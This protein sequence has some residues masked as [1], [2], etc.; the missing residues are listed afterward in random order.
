VNS[1]KL[2]VSLVVLLV[3]A[4]V[5]SSAV[6]AQ[7][8]TSSLTGIIWFDAN[9]NG[10]PDLQER[11]V[12][13]IQVDLEG[14]GYQESRKTT[15]TGGYEFTGLAA[16]TYTIT[17]HLPT[18]YTLSAG[19]NGELSVP[20]NAV[21]KADYGIVRAEQQPAP[22]LIPTPKLPDPTLTPVPRLGPSDPPAAAPAAPAA[23]GQRSSGGNPSFRPSNPA[24]TVP[25]TKEP[26]TPTPE[27]QPTRTPAPTVT[28]TPTRTPPPIDSQQVA[29]ERAR[30][31]LESAVTPHSGSS[32]VGSDVLL[33]V[34]FRSAIDGSDYADTNSGTAALA[35]ALESYGYT[36]STADLRAL[37]NV[38]SRTYDVGHPPRIDLLARAAEL[39]SV[40]SIGLYQGSRF[41]IWSADE[42]R[43]RVTAGYPVLT[44][45]HPDDAQGEGELG[46]E[47]YVLVIG[48]KDGNLIYHDPAYADKRGAARAIPL[49]S[50]T[51]VWAN[52]SG[53][54]QA[55]GLA[56]GKAELSLF[57]TLDELMKAQQDPEK[58]SSRELLPGLSHSPESQPTISAGTGQLLIVP[59]L[60]TSARTSRASAGADGP[61]TLHPI[62]LAFWVTAGVVALKVVDSLIRD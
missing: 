49:S 2:F 12:K 50:M 29:A 22:T 26:P 21:L 28:P 14:P 16:A 60:D 42:V 38:L 31:A 39:A 1:W 56:L 11:A 44:L 4:G 19:A 40:R 46:R 17:V 8:R 41:A 32:R 58:P 43:E 48:H 34:P 51:K 9:A 57:A 18:G 45:I 35:M 33:D 5:G 3:V 10:R 55:A 27:P 13:N 25:P 61:L 59:T 52:S 47:R 15:D 30:A 24:S 36:V 7:E 20:S 6:Q 53:P 54:A 23:P 37:A 62:L